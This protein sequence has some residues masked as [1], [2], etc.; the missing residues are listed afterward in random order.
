MKVEKIMLTYFSHYTKRAKCLIF[1]SGLSL[2]SK[3][4]LV[5]NVENT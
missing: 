5:S 1:G 3:I 2:H 4:I